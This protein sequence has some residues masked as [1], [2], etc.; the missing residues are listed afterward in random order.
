MEETYPAIYL[1]IE[2]EI[3]CRGALPNVID[4]DFHGGLRFLLNLI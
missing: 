2:K 1:K 3:C 4:G